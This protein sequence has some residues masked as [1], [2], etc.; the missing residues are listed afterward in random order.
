[1]LFLTVYCLNSFDIMLS[2]LEFVFLSTVL[3]SVYRHGR[4]RDFS[5]FRIVILVLRR[6]KEE[7]FPCWCSLLWNFIAAPLSFHLG[8]LVGIL[9]LIYL[10]GNIQLVLSRGIHWTYQPHFKAGPMPRCT[11]PIQNSFHFFW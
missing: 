8:W 7:H 2:W 5:S 6:S 10:R 4:K 3:I 9:S 11:W 1:M